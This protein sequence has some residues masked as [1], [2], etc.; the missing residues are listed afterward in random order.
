VGNCVGSA[1]YPFF[2]RFLISVVIGCLNAQ[3][4]LATRFYELVSRQ[5]AINANTVSY[6]TP[7]PGPSELIVLVIDGLFFFVVLVCVGILAIWQTG[8]LWENVSTIESFELDKVKDMVG[9]GRIDPLD[10]IFPYVC[11]CV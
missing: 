2:Y 5:S 1:N 9:R 8:F 4:L 3:A 11:V 10:A 6:S 7:P